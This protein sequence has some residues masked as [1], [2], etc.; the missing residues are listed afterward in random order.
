MARVIAK[1]KNSKK[2][3]GKGV[4]GS[5]MSA[6]NVFP[7]MRSVSRG[8]GTSYAFAVDKLIDEAPKMKGSKTGFLGRKTEYLDAAEYGKHSLL[9]KDFVPKKKSNE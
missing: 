8:L 5:S 2:Q 6:T 9:P 7:E 3:Q 1:G 4:S